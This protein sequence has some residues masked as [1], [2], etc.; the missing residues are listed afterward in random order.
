MPIHSDIQQAIDRATHLLLVAHRNPDGDTVGSTLALHHALRAY[1]K[2]STPVCI[3]RIPKELGFLPGVERFVD[4]FHPEDFDAIVVIDCADLENLTG[5]YKQYPSFFSSVPLINIDHHPSNKR[6]G[7]YQLVRDTSAACSVIM[8]DLLKDFGYSISSD[9]ATCL[10]TGILT[11]TGGFQHSNTSSEVMRTVADLLELGAEI[12][13]ISAHVFRSK[14]VPTLRLWG[15]VLSSMQ[16]AVDKEVIWSSA[17][18]DMFSET[19]TSPE[20]L[21]GLIALMYGVPES[22]ATVLLQEREDGKIKGSIRTKNGEDA[23]ELA[24]YFGGGGHKKAAGFVV[25]TPK[26]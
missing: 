3:D 15:N 10:L 20:Q 19:S 25:R 21:S 16:S 1:G 4:T 5:F 24:G 6:F 7:T 9:I 12:E 8:Y 14:S 13:T 23:N 17:T 18:Q 11:D 2:K 22:K 26:P